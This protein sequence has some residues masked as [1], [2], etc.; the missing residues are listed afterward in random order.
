MQHHLW[1]YCFQ[2]HPL[3]G[4]IKHHHNGLS[5]WTRRCSNDASFARVRMTVGEAWRQLKLQP[6]SSKAKPSGKS[7]SPWC[8]CFEVFWP[9]QNTWDFIGFQGFHTNEDLEIFH[10]GRARAR[11]AAVSRIGADQESFQGAH[12]AGR[13]IWTKK[14]I[15]GKSCAR[16]W[17]TI[18]HHLPSFT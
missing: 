16:F 14:M 18:Y 4:G 3:F 12:Q 15:C 1:S 5:C 13:G 10:V 6:T 17:R 9:H 2:D 7:S 11:M 8:F